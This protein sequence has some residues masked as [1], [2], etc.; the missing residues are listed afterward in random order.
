MKSLCRELRRDSTV[1]E[2]I[3]WGLLRNRRLAGMKFRR[4][5]TIGPFIVDFYCDEMKLVIEVDGESHAGRQEE[6][7]KRQSFLERNGLRVIRFTND[8]VLGNLEGVGMEILK[9][10]GDGDGESCST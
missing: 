1:P 10:T 9:C 3:L 4:Q 8:E 6:D 2:R 5:R 7:Q